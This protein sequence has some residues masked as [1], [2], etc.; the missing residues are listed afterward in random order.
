MQARRLLPRN[1][2]SRVREVDDA[3]MGADDGA[4]ALLNPNPVPAQLPMFQGGSSGVLNE[5]NPNYQQWPTTQQSIMQLVAQYPLPL[6][7]QLVA[8]YPQQVIAQ[9]TTQ[10]PDLTVQSTSQPS[11]QQ[12]PKTNT[13][14]YN[15]SV[16]ERAMEGLREAMGALQASQRDAL[17]VDASRV[18]S[19]VS[20]LRLDSKNKITDDKFA[21]ILRVTTG[22]ITHPDAH[23]G[24]KVG[25]QNDLVSYTQLSQEVSHFPL[26]K[27]LA[28]VMLALV[29]AALIA[30]SGIVAAASFG[31]VAPISMF[32]AVVGASM[33]VGG[34]MV[35]L[36]VVGMGAMIGSGMLLF[37]AGR[38]NQLK[39]EMQDLKSTA[40]GTYGVR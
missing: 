18:Y 37:D 39:Q 23:T 25:Y 11:Q 17:H 35:A 3:G 16:Y 14:V 1:R 38:K 34:V 4:M 29:G 9:L 7:M 10:Y 5:V 30:I 13:S 6:I 2:S 40:K 33:V 27:V 31:L 19:T 28:G 36:G 8:L 22:I 12:R 24:G 26:G 20:K 21:E 15:T 32:G